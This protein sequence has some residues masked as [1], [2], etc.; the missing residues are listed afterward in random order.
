MEQ[1]AL[2]R[3]I[4]ELRAENARLAKEERHWKEVSA[5]YAIDLAYYRARAIEFAKR[6]GIT[7]KEVDEPYTLPAIGERP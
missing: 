7:V 6:L 3:E 5:Q 2:A 1:P 4:D